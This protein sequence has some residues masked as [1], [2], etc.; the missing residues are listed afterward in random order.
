MDAQTIERIAQ[1]ESQVQSL[2]SALATQSAEIQFLR[3][4]LAQEAQAR[5]SADQALCVSL[6]SGRPLP[7]DFQG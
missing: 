7:E 3:E 6:T 5:T 1:L 4:A 2:A